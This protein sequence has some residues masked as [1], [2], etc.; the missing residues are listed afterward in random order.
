MSSRS[1]FKEVAI[2]LLL[3]SVFTQIYL[4]NILIR[5]TNEK[6]ENTYEIKSEYKDL[7]QLSSE[8]NNLNNAVILSA[9]KEDNIWCVQLKLSGLKQEILDE[10]KKLEIYEIKNYIIYK[11]STENCV[12]IDIYGNE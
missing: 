9:N 10:M 1:R 3:A 4:N 5:K 6:S 8:I 11:N 12:I 2:I 7:S